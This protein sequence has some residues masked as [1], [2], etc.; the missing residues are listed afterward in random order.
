MFADGARF[1]QAQ[2]MLE[3]TAEAN[4]RNANQVDASRRVR[5][6]SAWR[7][8]KRWAA[9]EAKKNLAVENHPPPV[10]S[11]VA[12]QDACAARP[13]TQDAPTPRARPDACHAGPT[14][15]VAAGCFYPPCPTYR[16]AREKGT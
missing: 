9:D 4:R 16:P 8:L 11:A 7:R 5:L 2:T 6:P 14:P 15:I 13:R 1:P 10:P 12:L 3:A